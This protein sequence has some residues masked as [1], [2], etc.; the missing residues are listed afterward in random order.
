MLNNSE[1]VDMIL[2]Y[3]E[4]NKHCREA[5]RVYANRYPERYHPPHNFFLRLVNNLRTYGTF[6]IRDAQRQPL[7]NMEP[8][9]DQENEVIAYIQLNPH[10]SLRHVAREFGFSKTKDGAPAHNAIIVRQQLNEM[11]GNRWMGTHGPVEWP[12]RSPD[13]T[14]LDFFLWGHLKTVIYA[15]PPANLQVLK[16]KITVACRQL[17]KEQ[18]LAAPYREVSRRLELCLEKNGGNFE[19]FIR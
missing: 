1:K 15:D 16:N 9:D 12:P 6:S 2:I 11:F 5:A 7:R 18:I 10:S 13:L 14:P 4:C 8:N 3:G 17:T 19:H